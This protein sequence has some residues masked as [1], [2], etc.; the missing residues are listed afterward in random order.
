MVL[1]KNSTIVEHNAKNRVRTSE[2]HPRCATICALS[3]VSVSK[4]MF[5]RVIRTVPVL[6]K[7]I[8]EYNLCNRFTKRLLHF[9]FQ[10]SEG[11]AR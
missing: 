8:V 2:D 9:F 3:D 1:S 7:K 11:E 6:N 10:R 4:A 5:V